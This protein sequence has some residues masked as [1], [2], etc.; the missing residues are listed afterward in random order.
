MGTIG[1]LPEVSGDRSD[2][3]QM[4][5]GEWLKVHFSQEAVT[6]VTGVLKKRN[7]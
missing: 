4:T 7:Q 5:N 6:W 2:E 1:K 3:K